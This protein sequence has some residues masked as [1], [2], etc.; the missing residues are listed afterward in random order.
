MKNLPSG[1]TNSSYSKN[2]KTFDELGKSFST[3]NLPQWICFIKGF[4]FDKIF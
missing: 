2:G 3:I 4:E 1:A